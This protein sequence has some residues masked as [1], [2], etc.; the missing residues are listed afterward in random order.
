MSIYTNIYLHFL[1]S[2][3]RKS[4]QLNG[5]LY[6][7]CDDM[8][9]VI[10][11]ICLMFLFTL[12]AKRIWKEV[13]YQSVMNI[14][15]SHVYSQILANIFIITNDCC[16]LIKYEELFQNFYLRSLHFII[17]CEKK[18]LCRTLFF[19]ILN[20]ISNNENCHI[21]SIGQN[22]KYIGKH[23]LHFSSC[24]RCEGHVCI[25]LHAFNCNTMG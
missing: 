7:I 23:S 13:K 24:L 16:H 4:F 3:S 15:F 19:V 25:S 21:S 2:S 6:C 8:E 12:D 14:L 17:I 18:F 10:Y 11:S 1:Y 20:N 22:Q 5:S 9:L